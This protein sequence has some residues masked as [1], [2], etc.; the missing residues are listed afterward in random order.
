MDPKEIL[1]AYDQQ[2]RMAY[3]YPDMRKEVLPHVTRHLRPAP[4]LSLIL[5]CQLDESN[6]DL[7]IQEQIADFTQLKLPFTWKVYLHDQP[8]DLGERL[9]AAG[10]EPDSDPPDAIMVLDLQETPD[11]LLASSPIEVRRITRPEEL[12]DVIRVEQQVWGGNFD[13]I[14]A[15]MGSHLPVPGY[16][17]V[18]VAYQDGQPACTGWTYYNLKGEFA[19][20][21]GGS[22]VPE[23]RRSGCYTA[24]L[25]A[26]VQ[27]AIQRGYRFLV[28]DAVPMSR[29]ILARH[30]FRVI[31]YA[32]SFDWKINPE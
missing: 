29:R 28:V 15:R 5:H 10:F 4:G 13:W 9:E 3:E 18:F 20:L 16:L 25:A 11:S 24:V 12:E 21:W 1:V 14:R 31:T 30:G 32:T 19:G 26:R 22:T 8:P 23:Q 7:V 2:Q 6:A 27:E 17:S